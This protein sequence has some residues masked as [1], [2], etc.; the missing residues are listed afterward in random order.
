LLSVSALSLFAASCGD[1]RDPGVAATFPATGI[2][3]ERFCSIKGAVSALRQTVILIDA[4]SVAGTGVQSEFRTQNPEL[5]GL[6]NEI[7]D[8]M[9]AFSEGRLALRE[10]T[11]LIVTGRDGSPGRVL[12]SGCA[13]L[14]GADEISNAEQGKSETEKSLEWFF[15]SGMSDKQLEAAK[16]Y[17]GEF[18]KAFAQV[19]VA[20]AKGQAPK[21]DAFESNP[22]VRSLQGMG[23]IV[24]PDGTAP[25][26]FLYTDFG[27]ALKARF[28]SVAEARTAGFA[29]AERA[30]L[31]LGRAEIHIVA[32]Q[33]DNDPLI[34]AFAE[35]FF[36]GS[37]ARLFSWGGANFNSMPQPPVRM[38][39]YTGTIDYGGV[40]APIQ[41]RLAAD[42]QGRLVNSWIVVKLDKETATP[43]TGSLVCQTDT[44]ELVQSQEK[45]ELGQLWAIDPTAPE[46]TFSQTMPF[47]GL[48]HITGTF[49]PQTGSGKIFDPKVS[50]ILLRTIAEEARPPAS[51]PMEGAPPSAPPAQ[52]APPP[53]SEVGVDAFA[54][55]VNKLDKVL[56]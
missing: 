28:A 17:R 1:S 50:K 34:R 12:F 35:A 7:G 40:K 47:S 9:K 11:T 20:A 25:R 30:N 44:C 52:P 15:A 39:G 48:R 51:K 36:L 42:V 32:P 2:R 53:G 55:E 24:A 56:F 46:P 23:R 13:P 10:R 14:R 26:I 19:P 16:K 6:L 18:L 27:K 3:Q 29:A 49:G 8:P 43:L 5:A 41:L 22:L 38:T 4:A 45:A 21:G 31:T 37:E 54:F 33:S